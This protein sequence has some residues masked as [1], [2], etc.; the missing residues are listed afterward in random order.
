VS[1]IATIKWVVAC[2][3]LLAIV[4]PAAAQQSDL[5]QGF[6][7]ALRGCEEWTLNP[8]SW[9][10]GFGPFLAKLGLGNKAGFVPSVDE[11]A[12]PPPQWREANHYL[13]IN[14]SANAGYILVVSD[15]MPFCHITGGG[16]TDLQPMVEAVLRSA[17]FLSRW[18]KVKDNNRN[19][20]AST[21]YRNRQERQFTIVISRAIKPGQRLDRVQMLATATLEL[22]P[23]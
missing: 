11:T 15:R 12:M 23:D 10:D 2:A 6:A 5:E 20:M 9:S 3:A 21:L 7:G 17:D 16:G 8:A 18:E 4:S 1:G 19:D 22:K 14:S 13:R